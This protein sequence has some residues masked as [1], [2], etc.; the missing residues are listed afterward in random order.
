MCKINKDKCECNAKEICCKMQKDSLRTAIS[1]L[2]Q[3]QNCSNTI[4]RVLEATYNVLEVYNC[5]PGTCLLKRVQWVYDNI[6][7]GTGSLYTGE[8]TK[9]NMLIAELEAFLNG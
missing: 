7:P 3:N 9:L 4:L 5:L 6:T 1:S 2:Q 8:K